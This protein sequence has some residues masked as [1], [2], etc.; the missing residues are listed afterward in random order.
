MAAE[1]SLRPKRWTEL[2]DSVSDGETEGHNLGCSRRMEMLTGER[3]RVTGS[4][5]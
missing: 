1:N 5:D 2:R 4:Q 3:C